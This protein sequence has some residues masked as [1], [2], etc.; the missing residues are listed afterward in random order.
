MS[1]R[2]RTGYA[3]SGAPRARTVAVWEESQQGLPQREPTVRIIFHGL[4]CLFFDGSSG[5]YVGTHNTS[6]DAAH[7]PH[8]HQYAV[9]VWKKEGDVCHQLYSQVLG[10][11][12]DAAHL[13]ITTENPE[14][15]DGT[16]VYTRDPFK[17]PDP[18]N[19]NDPHDWRWII[20]FND[21]YPDGVDVDPDTLES[22]VTIDNGLFYTLS[23]TCAKFK[24]RPEDD[25]TGASD[26]KIGS[27]AHHVA[28]NIYLRADDGV[29]TLTGGP[30]T[31]PLPLRAEPN[32]T[33]QV[34]ITNNC[35]QGHPGCKFDSDPN[36]PKEVRS[37]FFL[38]YDVFDQHGEP[39]YE[40]ILSEPCP[41]IRDIDAELTEM[42]VCTSPHVRSNDDSPCG[43]TGFSQ[44]P[45]P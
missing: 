43:A 15:F 6:A 10:N 12:H 27:V 30:F 32:V 26:I 22:G 11:P 25:D 40:L 31:D 36:K 2:E 4:L 19:G 38:Y 1:N 24:L 3:R 7:H 8:P 34:D 45:P 20:D 33:Y 42:G 5:C 44:T 14:L 18:G 41:S 29:V 9:Q 37:D 21:L 16:Y 35:N 17:R 28:A 23:K 39:E 13:E